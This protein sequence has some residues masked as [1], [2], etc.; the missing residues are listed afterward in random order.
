ITVAGNPPVQF[1][2]ASFE[3][4]NE[5]HRRPSFPLFLSRIFLNDLFSIGILPV[6]EGVIFAIM[7]LCLLRLNVHP[8][9]SALTAL[10]LSAI[11]LIL[12]SVA[13]KKLLVGNKWGTSHSTPFWSWRHFAYFFSQDCFFVWCQESL[14]FFA[15]TAVAN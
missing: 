6:T 10:L 9:F 15:G 13:V 2:S 3:S 4:E 11:S 1:A 12:L 5:T 8:V 14:R 7:Y